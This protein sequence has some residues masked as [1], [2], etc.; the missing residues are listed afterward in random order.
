MYHFRGHSLE[1]NKW[2]F[3]YSVIQTK[4]RVKIRDGAEAAWI[5]VE[6]K[7]LGIQ[8][9]L[10]N[11]IKIYAGD[12]LRYTFTERK[13]TFNRYYIV[14]D[15]SS[16]I[17]LEEAWR[18]YRI[19]PDTFDIIRCECFDFKGHRNVLDAHNTFSSIKV[20][21]DIWENPELAKLN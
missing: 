2:V 4:D 18:D 14:K 7:T 1:L 20:V 3:G 15:N 17:Y 9:T 12:I 8:K 16:G 19:D 11:G 13:E 10:A 5:E 6:P 21:G